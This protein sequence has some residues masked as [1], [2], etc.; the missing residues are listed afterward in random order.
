MYTKVAIFGLKNCP[1]N[2]AW[3]LIKILFLAVKKERSINTLCICAQKRTFIV[4]T[5]TINC[6]TNCWCR[7]FSTQISN[8]FCIA[9]T[10]HNHLG[11]WTG[12]FGSDGCEGTKR[13]WIFAP[14]P[15]CWWYRRSL[16]NIDKEL[17]LFSPL[18]IAMR[19]DG[20][21]CRAR[22]VNGGILWKITYVNHRQVFL[23]KIDRST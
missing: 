22:E 11:Y 19:I 18:F 4:E 17:C 12:G 16:R 20:S 2:I 1:L 15:F 8:R 13:V 7:N 6:N 14:F 3:R 9:I 21:T 10:C 5:H 23:A